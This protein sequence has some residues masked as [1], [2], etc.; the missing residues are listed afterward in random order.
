MLHIHNGDSTADR[1][2]LS[3]L[4]GEHFAFREALVEGPT[5]LSHEGSEWRSTRARHLSEAYG[6]NVKQCE[7]GLEEQ[8]RKLESFADHE[9]V[10]L[11]FEHDLFCQINL[12][13]LLDWF[14]QRQLG[15]TTLSLVCIDSFPGLTDFRGLGQLGAEQLASLF[16]NREAVEARALELANFSWRAYCSPDPT[17]IEQMLETDTS[18]LPFL[19]AAL[20]AHLKRF[21]SVRN[22]L[23][24]IENLS[25]E[26]AQSQSANFAD[27]FSGFANSAPVYGFG[28]A[29]FGLA[30]T[31]LISAKH[32][33][34]TMTGTNRIDSAQPPK[35]D[36]LQNARFEIT[37]LGLA[38]LGGEVD[39]A[40][41]NGIDIWLGGVHLEA[42][43]TLWRWNDQSERIVSG[44]AR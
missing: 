4:P 16:P 36:S 34:L 18:A 5:P 41:V 30:L 15:S 19:G 21:P 23:G 1:A 31:R 8:E 7:R 37:E 27:L 14:S 10:V 40:S 43:D 3:T 2:K 29:Q 39:F 13:Y 44:S 28:D 9:E 32:P 12:L 42:L 22:G 6:V 35:L 26:L 25:L 11:W 20:R 17:R 38:I 24:A 33:A